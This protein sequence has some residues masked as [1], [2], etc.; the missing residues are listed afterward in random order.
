MASKLESILARLDLRELRPLFMAPEI[1]VARL[2]EWTDADLCRFGVDRADQRRRL[3]SAIREDARDPAPVPIGRERDPALATRENP[4]VNGLGLPFVPIVGHQTLFC[5]WLV[6]VLDYRLYCE[7]AGE[8]FP[9]C[10]FPQAPDHPVVG[11]TWHEATAFCEWLTQRERARGLLSGAF[12]FRL[13]EDREW[14]SAVGLLSEPWK[15][16]Q[17]RSGKTKGYPWGPSFPPPPGAGN[18]H[19]SLAVD[20]FRETSPVWSF[21]PNAAGIHDLGGNV[22]EWCLDAYDRESDRRVLRGA[23]CFNDDDEYLMS[24]FRDKNA[25]DQRRNNNGMRIVLAGVPTKDVW[26]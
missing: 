26:Y 20:D 2:R 25:P 22:W 17:E 16:P 11:V 8:E 9:P 14:S 6:R 19:P 24:S 12:A 10:D 5:I 1:D 3:L 23:S 18:Y 21:A 15:T 4:F 7:E 13:P